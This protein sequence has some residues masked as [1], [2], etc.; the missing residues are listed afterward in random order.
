M[1]LIAA[2]RCEVNG[3]SGVVVCADSQEVFQDY[4]VIVDKIKPLSAGNYDLIVGGGGNFGRLIDGLAKAFE[5]GVASWPAGLDEEVC[6]ERL[7]LISVAYHASHV[8]AYPASDDEKDM[9]FLVC[10]R[11]KLSS[12]VYLWR[13]DGVTAK[14]VD[15]YEIIGWGETLYKY[16]AR[17]LYRHTANVSQAAMIGLHVLSIGKAT[18]YY[19]DDPF[20][21]LT[22]HRDG[23]LVE[24]PQR[25]VAL[26]EK[27]RETD[28]NYDNLLMSAYDVAASPDSIDRALMQFGDEVRSLRQQAESV[29]DS[30]LIHGAKVLQSE[31]R[32]L[33]LNVNQ[34]AK[35][36]LAAV[37]LNRA[38]Y[39]AGFYGDRGSPEAIRVRQKI[40]SAIHGANEQIIEVITIASSLPKD[41][42][43]SL[44]DL[45]K[46]FLDIAKSSIAVG[47][48]VRTAYDEKHVD[49]DQ[50]Y[51]L[52]ELLLKI[53][54]AGKRAVD[55]LNTL[56][57]HESLPVEQRSELRQLF[58][59]E[60]LA[61]YLAIEAEIKDLS[62]DAAAAMKIAVRNARASLLPLSN[63]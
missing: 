4:R 15:T 61:P 6:R 14:T 44:D 36:M 54:R 7:E 27:V 37:L 53:N 32:Q 22:V 20:Q 40:A 47:D 38:L 50:K 16:E 28:Q 33:L 48:M 23:I 10:T 55:I 30:T 13:L 9:S 46:A 26:Q 49:P 43:I 1:T 63:L 34:S 58:S 60:I 35:Q 21:V 51:R 25:I 17:K 62:D 42:A 41:D 45:A 12:Q 24:N 57:E 3:H 56:N 31:R 29:F 39:E 59:D 2:F 8:S 52:A 11:D 19:I 5:K 18:S